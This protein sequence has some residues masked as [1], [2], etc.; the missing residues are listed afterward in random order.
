MTR[1]LRFSDDA[2]GHLDAIGLF[3]A[4]QAGT[5][6]AR[7]FVKR[8]G[9]R[10]SKVAAL[11]GT[12]GSARPELGP[13]VRSTPHKAYVIYFRYLGNMVE[14]VGILDAHRDALAYFTDH[15]SEP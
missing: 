3:I 6:V 5:T 2:L 10:C 12:L 14:I 15:Q 11:P 4:Q 8:L 13:D 1:R 9:E 7:A